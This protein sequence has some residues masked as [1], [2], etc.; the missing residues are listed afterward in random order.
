MKILINGAGFENK[1]AEAM[2]RTV[3]I[4]FARR[5]PSV[6]F[7]LWRPPG[8]N[9]RI[10]SASGIRP[11][12]LPFYLPHSKWHLFGDRIGRTLWSVREISHLVGMKRQYFLF[13]KKKMY[14]KACFSYLTRATGGFDVLIDISGFAYRDVGGAERA[15][16]IRPAIDYCQQHNKPVF[17]LP[18]A[19]GS[20]DNPSAKM[21]ISKLLSNP[22]V[23]FYSRD[24]SS[25]R[26]LEYLLD[27]DKASI[28]S[29]PD[30]AFRF[31][32]GT[33]EQGKWIL[34]NMGCSMKRPIVGIS[35]N[36]RVFERFAEQGTGNKYLRVLIMLIKH[37]LESHDVDVVLQANEIIEYRNLL[38]DRYLCSLI[39]ASVNRNDRCFMTR[40]PLT[41]EE[42]KALIGHFDYIVGSRFH[43]FIFAFSHGIPGM[44]VSWSHKYREL[45]SLF[46]LENDVYEREDIDSGTLIETFDRGWSNRQQRRALIVEASRDIQAKVDILF[47]EITE[48]ILSDLADK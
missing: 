12:T 19:W 5:L 47:T 39:A 7:F 46:G 2:L 38:D 28:K 44:A 36:M 22:T 8:S 6:E 32:G 10:A 23:S 25:S 42:S 18:Q 15:E 13:N 21:A 43:S 37:C 17:F 27:K 40:D 4:E 11:L 3:Q 30:I 41:A 20:F 14:E 31:Q 35:P 48:K 26:Y 45:F 34:R 9:H 29:Y 33:R 1:G 16:W 24:E